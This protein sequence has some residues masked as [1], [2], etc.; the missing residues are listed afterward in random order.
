MTPV[1]VTKCPPMELSK[2]KDAEDH[3]ETD[4]PPCTTHS[5]PARDLANDFA[6]VRI[7]GVTDQHNSGA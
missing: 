5:P 7:I 4:Y 2:R 1:I 6:N 3:L